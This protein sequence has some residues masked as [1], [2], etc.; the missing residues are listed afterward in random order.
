[1]KDANTSPIGRGERDAGPG[2]TTSD[3][4]PAT[5]DPPSALDLAR[6]ADLVAAGEA[7]V[8][9]GLA[10]G[11]EDRLAAM[12]RHRLRSRL[13]RFIARQIALDIHRDVGRGDE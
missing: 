10:P 9:G 12:V 6:L 8:P 7:E 3:A 1:M 13:V 4:R 5:P 11:D 2:R